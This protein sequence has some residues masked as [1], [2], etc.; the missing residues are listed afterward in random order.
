MNDVLTRAAC[1]FEDDAR[2]RQNIAKDIENEIAIAYC[3]RRVLAVIGHL[4][5]TFNL[6]LARLRHALSLQR[7]LV[8]SVRGLYGTA[9]LSHH[10][11]NH[12]TSRNVTKAPAL[13]ARGFTL[14]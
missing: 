11:R 10:C 4:P 2:R 9:S 1:D 8:I 13:I 14:Q 6:A 7:L 3:R 5:R 12:A